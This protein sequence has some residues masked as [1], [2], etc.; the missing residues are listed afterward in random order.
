VTTCCGVSA[1]LQASF[2]AFD[3]IAR[4]SIVRKL[5]DLKAGM[6]ELHDATGVERFGEAGDLQVRIDVRRPRFYRRALFGGSVGAAEGYIDG[7]CECDDLT[8]LV[9][10]FIRDAKTASR[11]DSASSALARLASRVA[12]SLR[13]NTRS[14]SRR[15]I[16][17]HYDLGNDFFS[18][19]L[20]ETLAYSSGIFLSPHATLEEASVEKFDRVCR[21]LDLRSS[22]S[23]LEIGSG[24]GGF[25]MHAARE[26]GCR[27]TTTTISPSQ[28]ALVVQRIAAAGLSDRVT[29]LLED[30]RDLDDRFDKLASI[31][32]IEAVGYRNL[33][34]FFGK[35]GE[36]LKPNGICVLQAITLPERNL[37]TYLRSP[38]FIQRHVFP[39]GFLPTMGTMLDSA[40]HASD[41]H[42]VHAQDFGLHYAETLR[43]WR[44]R[45]VERLDEVRSL[46][47]SERF[48][49]LWTY[50][51]CYCEAAFEEK[52][53]GV[54][55]IQFDKP[56]R[57]A[58]LTAEDASPRGVSRTVGSAVIA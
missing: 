33:N 39:G 22:D 5:V 3:R 35:C 16:R 43:Q 42:F 2:G 57:Q 23:L 10:L 52:Q 47:Y 45:F 17:E 56:E 12:H 29:V 15:N 13:A 46:G 11:L 48:I 32:M 34:A 8:S 37:R 41:L 51:L 50:Y 27:V 49:R 55:Q 9:R 20:D 14:G 36:L 44:R 40:S 58:R 7:D 30:Y 54:V 6:L 24:W 38:D 18:L 25:A 1:P 28:H 4:Q 21:K 31:E 26:Y 19:W 53:I